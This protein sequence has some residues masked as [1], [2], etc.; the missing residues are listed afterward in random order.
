MGRRACLLSSVLTQRWR[1]LKH[2][3]PAAGLGFLLCL[4]GALLAVPWRSGLRQPAMRELSVFWRARVALQVLGALWLV[5]PRFWHSGVA[6]CKKCSLPASTL[7]YRPL[8]VAM[9]AQAQCC[10]L[11][12]LSCN[13]ATFRR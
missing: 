7:P 12:A 11:K 8:V 3:V 9:P 4:A 6:D 1:Y 13:V 10:F 2:R 5:R